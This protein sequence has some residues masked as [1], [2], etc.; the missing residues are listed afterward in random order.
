MLR[1]GKGKVPKGSE[2]IAKA[3][4]FKPDR[5]VSMEQ[6][7]RLQP[8]KVDEPIVIV[9]MTFEPMKEGRFIIT[10]FSSKQVYVRGGEAILCDKDI[11]DDDADD[12]DDDLSEY[13][14]AV[15]IQPFDDGTIGTVRSDSHNDV[16]PP[17]QTPAS[18][19][20]DTRAATAT[21][22]QPGS[23]GVQH[24]YRYAYRHVYS[25]TVVLLMLSVARD[26]VFLVARGKHSW[27]V[28]DGYYDTLHDCPAQA[29]T[30]DTLDGDAATPHSCLHMV[31][32]SP[33]RK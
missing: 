22:T 21:S 13:S 11:V 6:P 28:L 29:F 15:L 8:T 10:I 19:K 5:D 17:R 27:M 7:R 12:S 26:P 3:L 32:P 20:S 16:Q 31:S 24:V 1:A 33:I 2:Y 18:S 9:P 25:E 30:L 23:S 14:K 4:P